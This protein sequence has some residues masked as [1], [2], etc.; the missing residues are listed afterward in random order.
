MKK[1]I[2]LFLCLLMVGNLFAGFSTT[3]YKSVTVQKGGQAETMTVTAP[4]VPEK[5]DMLSIPS[6]LQG[7]YRSDWGILTF[8]EGDI[9][10]QGD[11][12]NMGLASYFPESASFDLSREMSKGNASIQVKKLFR[13][14]LMTIYTREG[15]ITYRFA[16]KKNGVSVEK[17]G[18]RYRK[19]KGS[20]GDYSMFKSNEKGTVGFFTL[21][22]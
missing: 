15:D 18:W 7:T 1:P 8:Q 4:T 13:T 14:Y 19:E 16:K 20:N 5:S 21:E 9:L 2:S 3:R 17:D 12:E 10:F 22:Q 11:M 6:W